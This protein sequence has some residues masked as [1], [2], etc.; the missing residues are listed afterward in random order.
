MFLIAIENAI[1]ATK[2]QKTCEPYISTN[3]TSSQYEKEQFTQ[4]IRVRVGRHLWAEMKNAK[5]RKHFVFI[6]SILFLHL[7]L[8]IERKLY[9]A[10]RTNENFLRGNCF[11]NILVV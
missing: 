1:M 2:Q 9:Y 3:L 8:G 11:F 7:W 4:H 6:A 10:M 5:M